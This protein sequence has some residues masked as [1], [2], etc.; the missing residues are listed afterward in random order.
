MM[1]RFARARD[2]S[3]IRPRAG[4]RVRHV[5]AE[6]RDEAGRLLATGDTTHVVVRT[7][8]GEGPI[9]TGPAA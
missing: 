4:A 7:D 3:E 9:G 1:A 2:G 8:A 6:L 5:R